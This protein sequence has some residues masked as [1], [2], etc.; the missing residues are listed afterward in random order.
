MEKFNIPN[1]DNEKSIL[2]TVRIKLTTLNKIEELSKINNIS[3]NRLINECIEFAL[4]NLPEDIS[5]NNK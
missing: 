4:N 5:N 3:I 2:K 1:I